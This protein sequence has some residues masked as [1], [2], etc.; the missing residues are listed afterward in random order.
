MKAS[1]IVLE[2]HMN[3]SLPRATLL[4]TI[5]TLL[6]S[7]VGSPQAHA[8]TDKITFAVIGDYGLASQN[9]ADVANLVKSWN[10]DFI[11][12]TGDN[13][14]N[15]GAAW[16]IDQNIGQYY[17]D[18][19]YPYKGKYGNG[20][21][22]RRFFPS[23]GNHDWTKDSDANAYFNYFNFTKNETFYD[24]VQ[25]PVHFFILDSD[26]KEPDGYT[27]TSPQAKWLK[28]VLT[29]STSPFN[30]VVFH[31]PP[32]S[33]GRHGSNEYMRWPFKEWGAD[34]VLNGHDHLYE[35]LV[36][37]GLPYFVN[38]FGGSDLYKFETV[39]PESQVRFNQDFGAM[40]VEATST[41]MKFQAITR[42]GVLVDEFV[43]GQSTPSVTAITAISPITTNAGYVNY[44][45]IFSEAVTGVDAADF[46][47]S[48]NI[49]GAMIETVSGTGNAYTVSIITGSGDGTL[50]L[51]LTDN[52]S[53]T[54]SMGNPL[55]GSG[56]GNGSFTSAQ[57]YTID[58][59][60]PIV[61][62]ITRASTNPTNAP[63]VDYSISFS[64]AVTG[65][66]FSDFSLVTNAGASLG[67][68]SGSG[69]LY[70]VSVSTGLGD[71]TVKLDFIDNDSVVDL[72]GNPANPG[73]TSG[74]TYSVDRSMPF[75]TSILRANPNQ[76]NTS[77]VD[78]TV[79]FSEAVN[80]VD[81]SDFSLFTL[82]GAVINSITG[83]G[84][85]YAVSVSIRPGNDTIRL[86]VIDDDS[87]L[88][89]A[90]NKLGD[91]GTGNGN[92]TNGEAYTFS[93]GVPVATSILRASPNPT[94]AA[95]VDF[96]VTFSETVEDV[97]ASD[98]IV[99][100]PYNSA[101]IN[102]NNLNPFYVVTVSTGTGDGELRL[103]IIDD[104][105]IHNALGISLGGEGIG[106]SNFTSGEKYSVDRT[107]PL[108]TSIVRASNNPTIN[109]S[110]DFIVTFSEPVTNVDSTDFFVNTTNLNSVVT[111]VQNANPFFVVSVNTGAG[112]GLLRL[113]LADNSSIT[114]LSG[115]RIL[116]GSFLNG[117]SFT[118]AKITV[119]FSAP[120]IL[121]KIVLTNNP[122]PNFSWSAVRY[123][124]AYEVFIAQDANFSSIVLMQTVNQTNYTPALPLAD[125]TYYMRVRAYNASLSPGKFSKAYTFT[126]D[127]TPP[128]VPT[129]VSP[130]NTSNAIRTPLMEWKAAVGAMQYQIELDNN[131]DFSSPEFRES[132]SKTS[133]RTKTLT[134]GTTYY[135]RVRAKDKIGN[136]SN[137]SVNYQFFVP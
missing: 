39:L 75:V 88:D 92:F 38:G 70:L 74:E 31:H 85:V 54:N 19:I 35:R 48:T 134:K 96:V 124:Q 34:A 29:A 23:M 11:V 79:S 21:T 132:T 80:G 57:A 3:T 25:G 53:V 84:N 73:F 119:N 59:T 22:T 32:Y 45:V 126:I 129:L 112:S 78:F 113:D 103:D 125:G 30:V 86:D 55:G 24:F 89:N 68:I 131:T 118:I 81:G 101:I 76:T 7:A 122:R 33:S 117:E 13:N 114:D 5:L 130:S 71:D 99:T 61:T 67:N 15:D 120:N 6:F 46:T 97:D 137:W 43:I 90:G 14:Y 65:V 36:V 108:V 42:A 93:L 107:P 111:N 87:I 47:L 41:Y 109:P 26:K 104:D 44:Q 58:K 128:P 62:A 20:A 17:H 136:W 72:A 123:S 91:A 116:N 49:N 40:R 51:E 127:T 102:I 12:T 94:S 50:R 4:L 10:P 115:N 37:N 100:G 18:Y 63:T 98:F 8:Q 60:N 27:S 1:H 64:E 66:D 105:S 133:L 83:S 16:S 95:S 82:N 69:N 77:S 52:D 135:W 28:K 110:V 2:L 9:E 106:N 56:L 121:S